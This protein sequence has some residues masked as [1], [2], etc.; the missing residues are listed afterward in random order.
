MATFVAAPQRVLSPREPV[1][2]SRKY[3]DK[4]YENSINVQVFR[5]RHIFD[6]KDKGVEIVATQRGSG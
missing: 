4:T 1:A 2:F 5:L 6:A 3:I